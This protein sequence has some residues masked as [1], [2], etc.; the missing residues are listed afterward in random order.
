MVRS[1]HVFMEVDI[2]RCDIL[3]HIKEINMIIFLCVRI[4][5]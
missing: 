1:M 5:N 2:S 4:T 3:L